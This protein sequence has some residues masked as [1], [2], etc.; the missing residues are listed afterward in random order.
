MIDWK[1]TG[2]G[3]LDVWTDPTTRCMITRHPR[4][5]R[6]EYAIFIDGRFIGTRDNI[7]FA[8]WKAWNLLQQEN[9]S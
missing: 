9:A 5:Y 6:G 4:K 3:W 2:A 7:G 1:Y 8:K